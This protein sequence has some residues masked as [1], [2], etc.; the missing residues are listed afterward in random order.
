[1][2]IK[3]YDALTAAVKRLNLPLLRVPSVH[4]LS[5]PSLTLSHTKKPPLQV[6]IFVAYIRAL[7]ACFIIFYHFAISAW[8]IALP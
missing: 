5:P 1:M 3:S 2:K 4:T 6:A 7:A 8:Q